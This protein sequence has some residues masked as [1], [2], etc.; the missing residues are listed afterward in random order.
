MSRIT[1]PSIRS[2]TSEYYSSSCPNS[3]CSGARVYPARALKRSW[4]IFCIFLTVGDPLASLFFG[5]CI[6]DAC[7]STP[8]LE[9]HLETFGFYEVERRYKGGRG[10]RRDFSAPPPLFL[11]GLFQ[12]HSVEFH[13]LAQVVPERSALTR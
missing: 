7:L 4:L 1:T 12:F 6:W 11:L 3:S 9:A 2:L 5:A 8:V 10:T 13:G